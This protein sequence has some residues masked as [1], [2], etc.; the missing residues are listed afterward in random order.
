M[1]ELGTTI[2]KK[3]YKYDVKET[4]LHQE[5]FFYIGILPGKDVSIILL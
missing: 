5:S 2:T 1:E 4:A 3:N